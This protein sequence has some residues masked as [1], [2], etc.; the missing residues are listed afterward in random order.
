MHR[1]WFLWSFVLVSAPGCLRGKDPRL[2]K[3]FTEHF[4]AAELDPELWRPTAPVYKIRDGA[5]FVEGAHNRP[6]WLQR[7]IPCD[8]RIDFTAWSDSSEGDIKV[9]VLGDGRSSARSEGNYTASGYV[10]V[11]GGWSNTVNTIARKDEHNARLKE[12]GETVVEAGKRYQ[13]SIRIKHGRISWY[14]DGRPF[15]EVEDPEP[16]C[17][18]GNEYFGFSNWGTPVHFDDLSIV[19][20]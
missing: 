3:A 9:E 4:D 18:P 8:V 15:M 14:L 2:D 1:S 20:L 17:G 16:L 11:F 7:R 6:L 12:D 5:L 13:F 10:I 19:P